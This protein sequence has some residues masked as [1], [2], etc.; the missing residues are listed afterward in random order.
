[1]PLAGVVANISDLLKQ[2]LHQQ[3]VAARVAQSST[4]SSSE[5]LVANTTTT[6]T[7]TTNSN[8]ETAHIDG[9]SFVG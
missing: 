7:T 3:T 4:Q 2:T 9:S 8:I 5:I 6:T 1:V